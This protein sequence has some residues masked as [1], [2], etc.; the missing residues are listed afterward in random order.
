MS[1]EFNNQYSR[2]I[3][4]KSESNPAPSFVFNSE[5]S[6]TSLFFPGRIACILALFCLSLGCCAGPSAGFPAPLHSVFIRFTVLSPKEGL[7]PGYGAALPVC[8]TAEEPAVAPCHLPQV[9]ALRSSF[10]S[11][12]KLSPS[13]SSLFGAFTEHRSICS[14][15]RVTWCHMSARA[16]FIISSGLVLILSRFSLCNSIMTSQLSQS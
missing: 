3:G 4:Q 10:C 6:S 11:L 1:V 15:K 7:Q 13:L 8:R 2:R 14:G 5:C 9:P 16:V 12:K